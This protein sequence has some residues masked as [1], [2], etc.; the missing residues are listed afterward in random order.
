[1]QAARMRDQQQAFTLLCDQP[2]ISGMANIQIRCDQKANFNLFRATL[3]V[4]TICQL[5]AVLADPLQA[6]AVAKAKVCLITIMFCLEL[7]VIFGD[8]SIRRRFDCSDLAVR[9]RH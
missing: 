1:M 3:P 4:Q 9:Y 8:G 6:T 2:A 7:N 5:N